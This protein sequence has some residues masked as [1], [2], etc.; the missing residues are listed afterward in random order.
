MAVR[1][2]AFRQG[3]SDL[4]PREDLWYSFLLEAE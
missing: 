4:Y 3:L 1:L 2:L